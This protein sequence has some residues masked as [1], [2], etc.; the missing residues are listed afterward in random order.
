MHKTKAT[1]VFPSGDPIT[2]KY[3]VI[4]LQPER[5]DILDGKPFQ[6]LGGKELYSNLHKASIRPSDCYFTYLIK[7]ADR[8]IGFYIQPVYRNQTLVD[9]K[10]TPEGQKYIDLLR[11]ELS[12]CS[13]TTIITLGDIP[14]FA[15]SDRIGIYKWR[16]SVISPTLIPNRNLIPAV[17][18]STIPY[19][20]YNFKNKRLLIADLI[21]ARQVQTGKWSCTLRNIII[22]PTLQQCFDFLDFCETKGLEGNIIWYDIEVDV[23]NGEMTCISFAPTPIDAISIPFIDEHGDY[24]T[25]HQEREIIL[26]IA[27]ILENPS[28]DSRVGGQN[29]AF[30]S[31][32]MLRK[33]GIPVTNMEDTMVAQKTLLPDYP[34]GL[35]FICTAYTDIPYYKDDGKYWLEGTGT[36][37]IGWRYNALDSIVC[38][39]AFPKQLK[40]LE[41][42]GNLETYK[43]KV[44]TIP[45]YVYIMEHGIKINLDS[46]TASYNKMNREAEQ[47][48]LELEQVAGQH[49]NPNSPKQI[50]S[51]FYDTLRLPAYKAKK[52]K[53]RTVDEKALKRI[54]RKGYK[55]AKLILKY[56]HLIKTASTFLNPSKIDSDS[57]IRCSYNPVGTRY[58]R[59][60]SSKNIFGKGNNLQN[61]PHSVLTHFEADT[62]YIFYG[63]DLSQAENRIV[64][65]EGDIPEMIKAFETG[66]DVHSLTA[67][68]MMAIFYG[69]EKALTMSVKSL[70]PIGD[71]TKTWRDWGK[72]ANHGLNYDL[73]PDSFSL[74]NEIPVKDGRFIVQTYH[75]IY[76]G[77][78]SNYHAYVQ[79]CINNGRKL[80][81]LMGRTTLFT[82]FINDSLYKDAYACIPQGTVGDIIDQRGVNYI[83]YNQDPLFKF[84]ELLI[85]V[86]D[87]VGFQV[88][89]PYHPTIPVPWEAHTTILQRVKGSLETP[90]YTHYG[91]KFV[92][93]VD[94]AM[95]ISLNKDI[96]LDLESIDSRTLEN[97]YEELYYN[98]TLQTYHLIEEAKV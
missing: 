87:Q 68:I 13:S 29:L 15:L 54:S 35:H 85:Q 7:D 43:N 41:S 21:R 33:Y 5:Q 48:L 84:V 81:N 91:R 47:V 97:S 16:S 49:L 22:R 73:G 12:S 62:N 78:R 71:G 8:Q 6:S 65:Y 17:D 75:N 27:S 28:I 76:P 96:G 26:R 55:E 70:A 57:R 59:A 4:G 89:S 37:E 36:F 18:P 31:T 40:A 46:M 56:R 98:K 20:N 79:E 80:I 9:Y 53:G 88:P 64:A 11:S 72:K 2:A 90:L 19:P 1:Y 23:F 44:A 83:Y 10:I 38:A 69:P 51:Y 58:A 3:I 94:I 66:Q 25:L 24:F 93:P 77:V 86:H 67:K 50:C 45:A 42:Q 60:S 34:V 63:P 39:E 52:G 30:D 74:E 95:G 61:Q 32:Y 82:D 14:L 92:I